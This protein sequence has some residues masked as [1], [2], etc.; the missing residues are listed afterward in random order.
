MIMGLAFY[1]FKSL[2]IN[3]SIIYTMF[4]YSLTYVSLVQH[5]L[6]NMCTEGK[7]QNES[8]QKG[9]VMIKVSLY[10]I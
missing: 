7:D 6:D 5:F 4:P 8:Q 9:Q 1:F 10:Q 3:F 2:L